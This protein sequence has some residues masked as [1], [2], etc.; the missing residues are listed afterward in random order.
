MTQEYKEFTVL[1]RDGASLILHHRPAGLPEVVHW[2][3]ETGELAEAELRALV[4]AG[5]RQEERGTVD[6]IWQPNL[7]PTQGDGWAGRPALLA[8][9]AGAPIF[10][11][12][13]T[14]EITVDGCKLRIE[15]HDAA[16]Q[17]A[18][19]SELELLAGG[20]LTLS[21]ELVNEGSGEVEVQH[22]ECVLPIPKNADHLSMFSG[23]WT[24]E[25][26]PQTIQMPRGAVVRQ[27]RRGRGGHDAPYLQ[28]ASAGVPQERAGELWAVHLGWSAD[29]TYRTDRMSEALTLIGAGELLQPAEMRLGAGGAYRTPKA[30]FGYSGQGL[31]GLSAGFHTALRARE[32]HP[33]TPRPLVLNTWEAVYFDHQPQTLMRLAE[34]AAQVG[35][36]RFVLDDGWFMARRDDT[37]GLGDWEVDRAVWPDGLGPLAALVHELGMEFGLWFEPEMVNPDSDLARNHPD[38]MLHNAQHVHN[39]PAGLSWRSQHVLDLANPHAYAHV[40]QQMGALIQELGIDFIKWDHNRD[41]I[42]SLHGQ[43]P[44]THEHTQAAYRLIRELKQE[45]PGLEIESCS[46]G[47]A[48]TDLGIL[49]YADRV[50]ASDSNDA[51]ERQDIQ[52]WTQLLLP[53]ELVGGHIG[54]ATSHSSGRTLDL[55]FRAATSL[56]GSAGFEWNLLECN[57]QELQ[58][59]RDFA[60]LY[61]EVRGLLHTGVPVHAQLLDPALR[62]SGVVAQDGSAGLWTIATVATL[63][64]ALPERIRLHGL[65]PHSRY[66]VRV[67]EE[68]GKAEFGWITPQWIAQGD[69]VLPG[70]LLEI[71][72]LQIPLLWPG[73]ALIVQVEEVPA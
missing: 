47:G 14:R 59:A 24:R 3:A 62:V 72:G 13:I 48:R 18:M 31:D 15:S 42:E 29:C 1:S 54:P 56:M 68:L 27:T 38:W 9:R 49:E 71:H 32:Q 45:H 46:S 23:R 35:V 22:L 39:P 51:I 33:S 66:R 19:R 63:E 20:V 30:W 7:L 70:R 11:R 5:A 50:W 25:K 73:Q 8:T 55:S 64:E 60:E 43:R 58:Q 69:L 12:W 40:R 21:H 28:I 6:A 53:P 34:L 52:R 67:R 4:A 41:L 10:P 65:K 61:K 44:G 57:E 17:L 26:A 2:G 16:N 36:E 37:K